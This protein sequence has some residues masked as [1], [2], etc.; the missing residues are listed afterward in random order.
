MALDKDH[1]SEETRL[2]KG[3]RAPSS[4]SKMKTYLK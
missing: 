3:N 1:I 2:T 4:T